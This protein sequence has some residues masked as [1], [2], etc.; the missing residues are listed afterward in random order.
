MLEKAIAF[1]GKRVALLS[2]HIASGDT[3]LYTRGQRSEANVI[4][5]ELQRMRKL[6]ARRK[7][8]AAADRSLS[9]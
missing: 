1:T 6:E 9:P 8:K 7:R 4:F 3:S 2:D 5:Q